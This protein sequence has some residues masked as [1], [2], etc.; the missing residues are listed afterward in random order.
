MKKALRIYLIT[1]IAVLMPVV[2]QAQDLSISGKVYDQHSGEPL[3][4]A[5]VKVQGSSIGSTTNEDGYFSFKVSSPGTYSIEVSYIGYKPLILE[6]EAGKE[7]PIP[8][9]GSTGQYP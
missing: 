6:A 9:Q 2:V 4:M 7:W 5:N 3:E 8:A 1:I